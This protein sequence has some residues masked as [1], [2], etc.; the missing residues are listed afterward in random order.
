M[1]DN[2]ASV[3]L[4]RQCGVH[5]RMRFLVTV[6]VLAYG[7][8]PNRSLVPRTPKRQV[9]GSNPAPLLIGLDRIK[10]PSRAKPRCCRQKADAATS[11]HARRTHSSAVAGTCPRHT[12]N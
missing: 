7:S 2:V 10:S 5:A 11:M 1:G 6:A 9:T 4:S 12:P 8:D 3:E